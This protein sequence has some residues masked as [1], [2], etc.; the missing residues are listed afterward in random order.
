MA[1]TGLLDLP[2]DIAKLVASK[3]THAAARSL[4]ST[5]TACMVL[6]LEAHPD[7]PALR[8]DAAMQRIVARLPV[9]SSSAPTQ[10]RS[11]NCITNLWLCARRCA[12]P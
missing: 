6:V 11:N 10:Q 8:V 2:W 3:L 9:G 4:A 12:A 1:H 7:L 5:S